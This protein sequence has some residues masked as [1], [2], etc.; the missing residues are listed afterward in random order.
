MKKFTKICLITALILFVVGIA[1]CSLFGMAGGYS[2]LESI[3]GEN[4][5]TIH[6][7]DLRF[8]IPYRFWSFG[9]WDD[10]IDRGWNLLAGG[11]ELAGHET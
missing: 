10:G 2:Q 3:R 8:G 11:K 7:G 5:L 6:I 4:D 9:I 1:F